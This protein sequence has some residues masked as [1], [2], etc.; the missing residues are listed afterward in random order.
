MDVKK[1]VDLFE[2]FISRYSRRP[3]KR[4]IDIGC[5]P[6]LQL[7]EIAR[8]G[9]FATGL[10]A[11]SRMLSHLRNA[12]RDQDLVLETIRADFTRFSVNRKADFVFMM[13]GTFSHIKSDDELHSHLDSVAASLGKGGLYLIENIRLDWGVDDFFKPCSWTATKQGVRVKTTYGATLKDPLKQVLEERLMLRVDDHGKR[14]VYED[15][16]QSKLVF[17]QELLTLVTLNG[18]FEFLGWFER[19]RMRKLKKAS[20]DNITLLRRR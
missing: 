11:S 18:K 19:E 16:W 10:D 13:M 2:R 12:A 5:G 7:R 15:V 1:Q 3:V 14:Y 9:Y 20:N 17:P 8:R 6:G 4:F